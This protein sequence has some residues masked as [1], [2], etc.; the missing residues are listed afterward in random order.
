VVHNAFPDQESKFAEASEANA[1][2]RDVLQR[3][4]TSTGSSSR[5]NQRYGL[6]LG[7]EDY[8][9]AVRAAQWASFVLLSIFLV[10]ELCRIFSNGRYFF[11]SGDGMRSFTNVLDV[12]LVAFPWYGYFSIVA[13]PEAAELFGE[14]WASILIVIRG[15]RSLYQMAKAAGMQAQIEAQRARAIKLAVQKRG[16]LTDMMGDYYDAFITVDKADDGAITQTCCP[17]FPEDESETKK[18]APIVISDQE[19]VAITKKLK[20]E[21]EDDCYGIEELAGIRDCLKEFGCWPTGGTT[22]SYEDLTKGAPGNKTAQ[23]WK[24]DLLNA[25]K[26]IAIFNESTPPDDE[27]QGKLAEGG[28]TPPDDEKLGGTLN[29]REFIKMLVCRQDTS[30]GQEVRE[31]FALMTCENH[32]MGVPWL[33]EHLDANAKEKADHAEESRGAGVP[34]GSPRQEQGLKNVLADAAFLTNLRYEQTLAQPYMD[35]FKNAPPSKEIPKCV[36]F[37]SPEETLQAKEAMLKRCIDQSSVTKVFER[38]SDSATHYRTVKNF[39]YKHNPVGHD[40]ACQ[41]IG[42]TL[43][44]KDG[45]HNVTAVTS[46][47]QAEKNGIRV[48]DRIVAIGSLGSR[49]T[50]PGVLASAPRAEDAFMAKLASMEGPFELEVCATGHAV[51]TN[52]SQDHH[53][54]APEYYQAKDK[55]S[56]KPILR[57]SQDG[58]EEAFRHVQSKRVWERLKKCEEREDPEKRK[59]RDDALADSA[60]RAARSWLEASRKAGPQ[61]IGHNTNGPRLH[62]ETATIIRTDERSAIGLRLAT[63]KYAGTVKHEVTFV[64]PGGPAAIAG[65]TARDR[66]VTVNKRHAPESNAELMQLLWHMPRTF[67]IEVDTYRPSQPRYVPGMYCT[68]PDTDSVNS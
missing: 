45:M 51:H 62:R 21:E 12:S 19:L 58:V 1:A 24:V 25:R 68:V 17:C 11:R 18:G 32:M 63:V 7:D 5:A 38:M 27:K 52:E 22:K 30:F 43:S 26:S 37:E 13:Y 16:W 64:E 29:F 46:G 67:E 14:N 23:K 33:Q 41:Q 61:Q 3:D 20:D 8:E 44:H 53:Y 35:K 60:R 4:A 28:T 47:S 9:T 66:I 10:F 36:Y 56:N 6:S 39:K 31:A 57:L 2:L 40:D 54:P 48:G 42:L 34:R 59:E 65:I 15:A 49:S 55:E 50:H